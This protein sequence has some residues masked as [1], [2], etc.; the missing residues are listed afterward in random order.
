MLIEQSAM[1]V[2]ERRLLPSTSIP[3]MVARFSMLSRFMLNIMRERS[4]RKIVLG[5]SLWGERA[6]NMEW[7]AGGSDPYLP[8][9]KSGCS[10][11][12]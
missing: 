7:R 11:P 8:D 5:I 12:I 4:D 1:R 3:R 10:R 6:D 9:R 2:V